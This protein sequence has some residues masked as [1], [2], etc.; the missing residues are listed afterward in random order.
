MTATSASTTPPTANRRESAILGASGSRETGRPPRTKCSRRRHDFFTGRR[1]QAT[2]HGGYWRSVHCPSPSFE[3]TA[4]RPTALRRR[5]QINPD[6][7]NHPPPPIVQAA[8][9]FFTF[10]LA[11]VYRPILGL[12]FLSAHGLLVDPVGRQVLDSKILK[13]L[14]KTPPP[15]GRCAPSSP[16]SSAP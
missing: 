5:R 9:V 15:P 13:P 10:F 6:V 14:S 1:Q 12:D 4:S 8:H 11:A 2:V 3:C 16:L 7:G